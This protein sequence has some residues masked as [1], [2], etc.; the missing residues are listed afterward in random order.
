MALADDALAAVGLTDGGTVYGG[1]G[2]GKGGK[3]GSATDWNKISQ[4]LGNVGASATK[5]GTS[6]AS[7]DKRGG[8]GPGPSQT[9]TQGLPNLLAT[10]LQM[11][12][13]AML[14]QPS[15]P[16]PPRASLLG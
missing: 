13:Q 11:H 15:A 5:A 10:L 12:R 8:E 3:G 9:A 14:A 7:Y 1:G 16:L 2:G 4:L 6:D